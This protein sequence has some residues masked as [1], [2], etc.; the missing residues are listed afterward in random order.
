MKFVLQFFG[1]IVPFSVFSQSD[2]QKSLSVLK[3]DDVVDH[4]AMVPSTTINAADGEIR[5]YLKPGYDDKLYKVIYVFSNSG[6]K[7]TLSLMPTGGM[8]TITGLIYNTYYIQEISSLDGT[9]VIKTNKPA[10][11]FT[12]DKK[13]IPSGII[14]QA[15]IDKDYSLVNIPEGV[16]S[17]E[18]EK[19]VIEVNRMQPAGPQLRRVI[20]QL[21]TTGFLAGI[22]SGNT[23]SFMKTDVP[24][25]NLLTGTCII[26]PTAGP[27]AGTSQVFQD[28]YWY[29]ASNIDN[30]PPTQSNFGA[31]TFVYLNPGTCTF[32]APINAV[33]NYSV[34]GN[35]G[36]IFDPQTYWIRKLST[37]SNTGFSWTQIR[38]GAYVYAKYGYGKGTEEVLHHIFTNQTNMPFTAYSGLPVATL[39]A[40]FDDAVANYKQLTVNPSLTVTT[41]PSPANVSVG[42][43]VP[44]TLTTNAD[45]I[46]LPSEVNFSICGGSGTITGDT[47][48][49]GGTE[50][51]VRSTTLCVAS[52]AV[53][54]LSLNFCITGIDS[55]DIIQLIPA[56]TPAQYMFYLNNAL[57]YTT[58][59]SAN[60]SWS[61]SCGF[62]LSINS[63]DTTCNGTST[64]LNVVVTPAGNYNYLW[65]VNGAL[66]S[67]TTSTLVNS[68]S[69]TTSY[70]VIATDSNGCRRAAVK[71][72]NGKGPSINISASSLT[73][74]SGSTVTLTATGG[75]SYTWTANNGSSV[76]SL[77]SGN[78]KTV[79]PTVNTVY[80]VTGT[81]ANG[82]IGTA[83]VTVTVPTLSILGPDATCGAASIVLYAS[84]NGYYN[85]TAVSGGNSATWT[86]TPG[87]N[88][89]TTTPFNGTTIYTA[90]GTY[91]GCPVSATK[92][93]VKNTGPS[94]DVSITGN[95]TTCND[96]AVTLTAN[97][98]SS[99]IWSNG[100][101]TSS[102]VVNPAVTT[103]YSVIGIAANG[104]RD[105]AYRTLTVSPNLT[106]PGSI[107]SSE[108]NCGVYDPAAISEITSPSGSG[109]Y[110]YIWESASNISGPWT[111][112]SGATG[113]S[114]DPTVITQ[115][116]YY[117]RSIRNNGCTSY[118]YN[119]IVVKEIIAPVT[120]G[121]GGSINIC[122]SS[123]TAI[124]LFSIITGEQS[125]G[126]WT[127]TSGTG[128]TFN[129]AAGTFIPTGAAT[130][131][132]TYT[133]SGTAP[134]SN[135]TAT[136]IVNINPVAQIS[137]AVAA[138]NPGMVTY[139]ITVNTNNATSVTAGAYAV[140]G[141]PSIWMI[142]NIPA[143]TNVSISANNSAGCPSSQNVISPVCICPAT[144]P[145]ASNVFRCGNGTVTLTAVAGANNNEIRWY[146]AATGGTILAIGNT[147]TTPVLSP[148]IVTYYVAGYN[149]ASACESPRTPVTVTI[150]SAPVLS[151]NVSGLCPRTPATITAAVQSGTGAAPYT[152]R[153]DTA[154]VVIQNGTAA[155]L[156]F[157]S[158]SSTSLNVTV[159]DSKGC[160]DTR[161]V[162]VNTSPALLI[163]GTTN[164]CTAQS[165]TLI[166]DN[167]GI[168][169]YS[170]RW[171]DNNSN[172]PSRIVA[173]VITTA[174]KIERIT[175]QGCK[176][177]AA[178]TISTY[179]FPVVTAIT[180]TDANCTVNDGTITVTATSSTTLEYSLNGTSWQSSNI[181]TGLA[182]GTYYVLVRNKNLVCNT[183]VS[184][185]V[186][187]AIINTISSGITGP[188]A[189][190]A[191]ETAQF[192]VNPA[193]AGAT[194][195]WTVTGSPTI[196]GGTNGETFTVFWSTTGVYTVTLTVTKNGCTKTYN[197]DINITP[198]VFA[199]GGPPAT[200]CQGGYAF[201]G[202]LPAQ[203]GPPGAKFSW[204]PQV[205]MQSSST[206]SQ[207]SVNPPFDM[208][209]TLTVT[210]P[211][212]GCTR[213][214]Q[215]P[216]HVNVALN[217]V[218]D[219][220]T[221]QLV[222]LPGSGIS[223]VTLGG[224]N[225]S[226]NNDPWATVNYYW[227]GVNGAPVAYLNSVNI[228]APVFTAPSGTTAGTVYKY[229]LNVY[230]AYN[231]SSPYNGLFC[232]SSDTVAITMATCASA[233]IGDLVWN[234]VNRNGIQDSGETGIAG[235]TVTLGNSN[236]T[237]TVTTTDANGLYVFSNLPAGTYSVTF[238][239][240]A[241]YNAATANAGS[242]DAVDSDPVNGT[243]NNIVL[244]S[245]EV[246]KTIDAGFYK[247]IS[248]SGHIW[249]D[250]NAMDDNLV[251]NSGA[252]QTPPAAN[253]P[254]GLRV[255]LVNL[256]TGLVERVTIASS[257]TGVFVFT[258]VPI[259]TA[260][261]VII[262]NI[263][264][265]VGS[266]TPSP[267]LPEG[268]SH[269][270]QKLGIT[271]GSDGIND[272]KL[273]VGIG[274]TDVI[275]VNFG[276]KS[277]DS[278][279]SG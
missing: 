51:T 35:G 273:N 96:N 72:V 227:Q 271:A 141:G 79:T 155:S 106:N 176:D 209:Y 47:L 122:S 275:N 274:T 30:L 100:L 32:S 45:I 62:A 221:D 254:I 156:V 157:T 277:G 107:G 41:N 263:A 238:T 46:K 182:A 268:W 28:G 95:S 184:D 171:L 187:I 27:Y 239:T 231:T 202:L 235:V 261:K 126:V 8:L 267:L 207:V 78:P 13:Y 4:I 218:A 243:V 232:P 256:T 56:G 224:A 165:T 145:A 255:Y 66:N 169:G 85:W 193:V 154:G 160:T 174:Y 279:P 212:N 270:G 68:Q 25:S 102:I 91:Q 222:C 178:I 60:V 258:N 164:I 10:Y 251:N 52:S 33:C 191:E 44:V 93:V 17:A 84:N 38:Q 188:T 213:T 248:L 215:V 20:N 2:I 214:A 114:Y 216:V 153:F 6:E 211:N 26:V 149:T 9:V 208:V 18:F 266:T 252:A 247:P 117:R 14:A 217:P 147:Y 161:S 109:S 229:V 54:G 204:S 159:T 124:D 97:G 73:V 253:I 75:I 201:I 125:G 23:A 59:K 92:T 21:R 123:A 88:S 140:S 166:A 240:P 138:C 181:F 137:S 110:Q 185:P 172:N 69:A 12:S 158:Q 37:P 223:T 246:N 113:I 168:T 63:A 119:N 131:V 74:C 77:G 40:M 205:F 133:V 194:Y 53:A 101:T 112:I 108:K 245:G 170:Y 198:A 136:A 87:W 180:K 83:Q 129:A 241:G 43:S 262:S 130:S 36:Y 67:T 50:G 186:T 173:P 265:P 278:V 61:M 230:K 90:S 150:N 71:I 233:S 276:I 22:G 272:G 105:T 104:C 192:L 132:F 195:T 120:A 259:N 29:R 1:V 34:L 121:T 58:C 86:G 220:G 7:N 65:Y 24:E 234:D 76:V 167:G 70:A 199:N 142:Q 19:N 49:V 257:T 237:T 151:L 42:T 127:R 148:G 210:D 5:F 80:T 57:P 200:I 219:A 206:A 48:K 152:Y 115:T 226:L 139:N 162:L 225:T 143:G 242:N 179:T 15:F 103:T 228:A 175:P 31:G 190:C 81:D 183:L 128:G 55:T 244:A 163:A 89:I 116:T 16:S 82:C 197:S 39:Q 189:I 64:T 264:V 99:Y 111:T 250:V 135:S 94:P 260:Y 144:A 269:T 203:A 249:H 134:C 196:T 146:A 118:L 236:G 98:A 11:V 177:T 3:F